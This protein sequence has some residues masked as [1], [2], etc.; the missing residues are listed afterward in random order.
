M[1]KY[2]FSVI[3]PFHNVDMKMFDRSADYMERQTVGFENIEW[4]IICHNCDDE[5]LKAV[6]ERVGSYEN[7]VIRELNNT[8]YTPS[9]PRNYAFQFATAD[10]V[11]F[12]DGDDNYRIDA[13]EKILKAFKKSKAQTI[14]FRR[15]YTLEKKGMT[16]ITETVNWNQA[17][18]MIIIN[19]HGY[20]KNSVYNDFPFFITSRAYDRRFL[21]KH[22][23]RFD[24]SLTIAE[25]A[26]FNF[27]VIMHADTFCFCPQL[28][29]YNYYINAGSMLSASKTDD[30]IRVMISSAEKIIE[31]AYDYGI[32][33]NVIIKTICFVLS[34]YV[35]DPNVSVEVKRE[36]KDRL[37]EYLNHTVPVSEGR[38][39]E[40]FNTLL[41]TL[42]QQVFS[43]ISGIESLDTSRNGVK[44]LMSILGENK[45]TDYGRRHHFEDIVTPRGYQSQVPITKYK[46][47]APMIDLATSIG[48][49]NIITAAPVKWYAMSLAGRYLP[50]TERQ[51]KEFTRCFSKSIIGSNVFV[52]YNN[53]YSTDTFN[54]GVSTTSVIKMS[55][56]GYLDSYRY[57]G[58]VQPASFTSPDFVYFLNNENKED[59]EYINMLLALA[60]RDVDQL[61]CT[62]AIEANLL[63]MRMLENAESLCRDLERG[64]V[65]SEISLSNLQKK[66]IR[67]YL[68]PDKE[69][70]DE[71]RKILAEPGL[72][73]AGARL[74]PK[75]KNITCNSFRVHKGAKMSLKKY[76][77]DISHSNRWV[78]SH[79]G[80]FGEAIEDTDLYK[81]VTG[82]C[83]Y[84]FME[85]GKKAKRPVFENDLEVGKVYTIIVTTP[86]GLYRFNTEISIRIAEIREDM[87]IFT[88]E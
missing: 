29:G 11:G 74:W 87:T 50:V 43:S 3:T 52:W 88:V 35:V 77:G 72:E 61:I 2:L 7:V 13:V 38:F 6:R 57:N 80:V 69:R 16:P 75:L 78:L 28:I 81:L 17:S 67:A 8:V 24:E 65:K 42:P 4:I 64:E 83:F 63:F 62:S 36:M 15:E 48:E 47:Y 1:K 10:Y 49:K 44:Y 73:N 71:V 20:L 39:P 9:S 12:L 41:N 30:E 31:R 18:E 85:K 54:D 79:A 59:V 23:I 19:K 70:A 21:N 34:R 51:Y 60:N 76:F 84:E 32:Y 5:H 25:D 27:D 56:A 82:T 55:I 14:A 37:G 22:K 66:L 33:P 26:F 53:I 40:P 58:E 46:D 45:Q 86:S 68:T